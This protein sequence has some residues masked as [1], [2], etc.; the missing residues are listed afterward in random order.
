MKTLRV[1][2]SAI[3]FGRFALGVTLLSAVA[4]RFGLWGPPG[5]PRASWGDWAHFVHY[6][7]LVNSFAPQAVIPALAWLSTGLEII[8]G[9]ALI[10]GFKVEYAAYGS[11]ILFALFAA[12][13]TLS[14][15]V[16]SALSYSVF[17]DAAGAFLLGALMTLQRSFPEGET[18]RSRRS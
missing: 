2:Q 8:L 18:R 7:G 10:A 17:A 4:D 14:L 12:A 1:V 3:W 15:G 5:S 9:I 11:A 16:K 6:C 13:M